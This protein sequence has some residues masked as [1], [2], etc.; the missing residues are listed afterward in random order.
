IHSLL[1]QDFIGFGSKWA[2]GSL[3][4]DFGFDPIGIALMDDAFQRRRDQDVAVLFQ[5]FRRIGDVGCS[6]HIQQRAIRGAM[7]L[8]SIYINTIGIIDGTVV[9]DQTNNN[10][11]GQLA[12]LGSVITY[13]AQAL[14]NDPF[15]CNTCR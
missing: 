7:G 9:F 8:G 2:V 12:L 6:R 3:S 14:D 1:V 10:R 13:V 15:A 5:S 11:T 4:D